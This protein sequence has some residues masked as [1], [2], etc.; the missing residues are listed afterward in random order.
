MKTKDAIYAFCEN[1][2]RLRRKSN[3][4]KAEMA[5]KLNISLYSLSLIEKNTLPERLSASIIIKIYSEFKIL[6]KD[7]FIL[8]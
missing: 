2:R 6:P 7:L 4:T 3:L 1:V 5:K 8:K